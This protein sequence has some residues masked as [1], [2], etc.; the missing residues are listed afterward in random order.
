MCIDALSAISRPAGLLV[1]LS[2]P[3]WWW[4]A[5]GGAADSRAHGWVRSATPWH[6][7][8]ACPYSWFANRYPYRSWSQTNDISQRP[9]WIRGDDRH[10]DHEPGARHHNERAFGPPDRQDTLQRSPLRCGRR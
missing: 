2:T 10:T 3:N 1:S 5:V 8:S 4:S 6:S 7:L 9:H